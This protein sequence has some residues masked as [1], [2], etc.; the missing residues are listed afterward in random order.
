MSRAV[1]VSAFA[2]A[3]VPAVALADPTQ[4]GELVNALFE[5]QSCELCH[6]FDNPA[7]AAGEPPYAPMGTWQGTMMANSAR[8]PVFW[9]ALAVASDDMPGETA[10]C[11]RC[12]APRAYL[13]G[14]ALATSFEQLTN[15][16]RQGVECE[17]CHRMV[18]DDAQPPGN[19]QYE[20][21][22]V[23]VDT[24]VP[25]RGPWDFSDGIPPPPHT[26]IH[27]PYIG[28]ARLCGTCHDVT[29]PV[30]RVDDDG[31]G[32]GVDFNEQRTYSE[33]L[34]SAYAVPGAGFASCQDCHM[35]PVTEMTGCTSHLNQYTHATGGR[36][37]DLVGA[38]RFMVELLKQEFGSMGANLISDELFDNT[39]ARMDELVG[40][41]ATLDVEAP[42]EVDLNAGLGEL[43][44]RVTNNTGHKLPSG[45]SEGRIMWL[46]VVAEYAGET[47]WSSGRWDQTA[48]TIEQD[49][50]L[51]TYDAVGEQLATGT[52][53]HLL[54]NDHWRHDT[55]IPPLGLVPDLQT[56][57]VGDRYALTVDGVWPNY[58]DHAYAFEAAPAIVDV[59]PDD[60]RDDEL[61]VTVRLRYLINTPEY[62]EFLGGQSE[63]GADLATLFD[64]AGGAVPVLLAEQAV[65]IPIVGFG[66]VT[67]TSSSG[68]SSSESSAEASATVAD[69][70]G[71]S[72]TTSATTESTTSTATTTPGTTES[73]EST[74]TSG[75]AGDGGGCG[76]REGA[77]PHGAWMLLAIAGLARRRRRARAR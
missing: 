71:S 46:E 51:R 34:A 54:L 19:A 42:D 24:N 76:C 41:A 8:D 23:L 47:V 52:T 11:V 44:V 25:R 15:E 28:T 17:L 31:T 50:Q 22:D 62:I 3:L 57:P 66:P 64:A 38:N 4:S 5:P 39:L 70:S 27:D 1:I 12:H 32:L 49:A 16:Q 37:H 45:Y 61:T 75:A 77:R 72:S 68:S 7:A 58:D 43:A 74:G 14:N 21:D 56:D 6:L 63:A 48:G 20:I 2:A 60:L 35:P 10:L 73:S 36:R 67:G 40:T 29:T 33:W 13:E 9:S 18:E 69:T 55:R 65:A 30:E 26:W 59:T 53:F